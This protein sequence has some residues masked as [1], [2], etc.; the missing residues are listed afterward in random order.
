MKT[1]LLI[2]FILPNCLLAQDIFYEKSQVY[3]WA[4]SGIML[5]EG[6]SKTSPK[7]KNLSYGTKVTVREKD[8][9]ITV[10]SVLVI[11]AGTDQSGL[12]T[13]GF[14]LHGYWA[15]VTTG[16]DSGYVFSGYLSKMT[17]YI[18]KRGNGELDFSISSWLNQIS[19]VLDTQKLN[20]YDGDY[21]RVYKNHVVEY[22]N[23]GEG[24]GSLRYT[25]QHDMSFQDGFLLLNYFE[26]LHFSKAEIEECQDF[27]LVSSDG[28]LFSYSIGLRG[29]IA[30]MFR[31]LFKD[32]ILVI[33]TG[34]GC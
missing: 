20:D 13:Q 30:S 10:D 2:F 9:G 12:K 26:D 6:R 24:G 31:I 4:K 29:G 18:P 22:L 21:T 7:I 17:P 28:Y 14:Y 11:P 19:K 16:R 33:E 8:N 32:G 34:G 3:V 25:F 23:V 27:E 1:L 15:F 5:R